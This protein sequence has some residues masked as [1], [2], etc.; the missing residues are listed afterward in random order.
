M[1]NLVYILLISLV[2]YACERKKPGKELIPPETLVPVLV[3]LHLMYSI[4]SSP[5]FRSIARDVDTIDTHSYIFEKYHVSKV[6]FDTTIAWY[7]R[8]PELFTEIYDEVVMQLSKL[9]DS[10]GIERE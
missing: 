3:D 2:L 9:S 1:R 6:K 10:L 8:H 7:S 5:S 4:Q